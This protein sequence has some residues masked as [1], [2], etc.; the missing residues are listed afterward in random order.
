MAHFIYRCLEFDPGALPMVVDHPVVPKSEGATSIAE[1]GAQHE[2]RREVRDIRVIYSSA[3]RLYEAHSLVSTTTTR[4]VNKTARCFSQIY[5][6]INGYY[7]TH[8]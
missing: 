1:F 3:E 8:I 5:T 2:C 4:L 6:I 7:K